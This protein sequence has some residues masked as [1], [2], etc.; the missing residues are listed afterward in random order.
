MDNYSLILSMLGSTKSFSHSFNSN[1]KLREAL[2]SSGYIENS[3][4]KQE[5]PHMILHETS[6]ALQTL[7]VLSK[8]YNQKHFGV[9]GTTLA[10][11]LLI[12]LMRSVLMDYIDLEKN[13]KYDGDYMSTQEYRALKAF[14]P[15]AVEVLTCILNFDADQFKTNLSWLY[16]LLADLIEANAKDLRHVLREIFIK[17][18]GILIGTSNM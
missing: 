13:F 7:R 3:R 14:T 10:E 9:P 11:S 17:S 16:P 12:P 6:S 2:L 1:T 8:L 4:A 15:I 5:L 18:V